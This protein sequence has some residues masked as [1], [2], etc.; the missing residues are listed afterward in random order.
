MLSESE[1]VLLRRVKMKRLIFRCFG[2]AVLF[3]FFSSLFFFLLPL[4]TQS[5][6]DVLITEIVYNTG[7]SD[8]WIEVM[9]ASTSAVTMTDLK[10][11]VDTATAAAVAVHGSTP[12]TLAAGSVAVIVKDATKFLGVHTGYSPDAV[13]TSTALDLPAANNT[14]IALKKNDVDIDAVTYNTNEFARRTG[15]SLHKTLGNVF[16]PA[17][18]TPG[19]VAVNP[20]TGDVPVMVGVSVSTSVAGGRSSG[21]VEFVGVGDVVSLYVLAQEGVSS[22]TALLKIGT[23]KHSITLEKTTAAGG[24]MYSGSHTIASGAADGVI[25]FEI[26]YDGKKKEGVV[27]HE[28]RRVSI[29]TTDP[30]IGSWSA[31]A[32]AVATRKVLELTVTDAN[33]P[34]EVSYKLTNS[35]CSTES[36]Y[37]GSSDTEKQAAV[38][39]SDSVDNQG[40]VRIVLFGS[41]G[42]GKFVCV[43]V[44]DK[45]GHVVYESSSEISGIVETSLR[46]TELVYAP[47]D[48]ASFEWIEVSNKSG[49][50]V[51]I[52]DFKI[53]D[54]GRDKTIYAVPHSQTKVAKKWIG[55]GQIAVIVRSETDFRSKYP[56]YRGQLFRSS[57]SLNDTG[58][59][60]GLKSIDSSVLFDQV[61]YEKADGAYRN[62][63][64][65]HIKDAGD[66]FEDSPSPGVATNQKGASSA[67]LQQLVPEYG[68]EVVVRVKQ[69]DG[70]AVTEGQNLF[71]TKGDS[72]TVTFSMEDDATVYNDSNISTYLAEENSS[73]TS[74]GYR[75]VRDSV[76]DQTGGAV[77]VTYTIYFSSVGGSAADNRITV[78]PKL[79]D[80]G[81]N[82]SSKRSAVTIVRTTTAPTLAN[83]S[84]ASALSFPSGENVI[85][86]IMVSNVVLGDWVRPIYTGS[87]GTGLSSYIA[88]NGGHGIYYNLLDGLYSACA[89]SATDSAGN[90]SNTLSLP[91]IR[92]GQAE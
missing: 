58:D 24:V 39:E 90:V 63:K 48:G 47:A 86:P 79:T 50:N 13:Y 6:G 46:I 38:T 84:N 67:L 62:G 15:V 42:N 2:V 14:K 72:A 85:V 74:A 17:P 80:E 30:V 25:Q 78:Y 26:G 73:S 77:D 92:V 65:L 9:N 88:R 83:V 61:T 40:D 11:Q 64:A 19:S 3:F 20:V 91:N 51:Q 27:T 45:A 28:G 22:P 18:E 10:V 59:V 23:A 21:G 37:T 32:N 60:V 56:A 41:A 68:S 43:K 4:Y 1:R 53:V 7:E 55:P 75:V 35:A 87:C 57:F 69:F 8:D 81:G 36:N 44:A 71:F 89:V 76:A 5:V 16:L 33:L 31:P 52:T 12:A 82:V 66:I 49:V 29:D 54:G 34:D 70:A